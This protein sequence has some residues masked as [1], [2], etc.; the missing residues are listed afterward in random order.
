[1]H[2]IDPVKSHLHLQDSQSSPSPGGPRVPQSS[3]TQIGVAAD[4]P[5]RHGLRCGWSIDLRWL[6]ST[7]VI[8]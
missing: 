4:S 8:P 7:T 3:T 2:T 6:Y 5:T 1:M